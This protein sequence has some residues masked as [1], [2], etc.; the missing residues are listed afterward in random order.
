[1][2]YQKK[3]VEELP[4]TP[5][6]GEEGDHA[7]HRYS[8][9]VEFSLLAAVFLAPIAI[10]TV[11]PWSSGLIAALSLISFLFLVFRRRRRPRSFL[12]FPMGLA[13]L[14]ACALVLLQLVPLP[15]GLLGFISPR[16]REI[17]DYLLAGTL[18]A[19]KWQPVS[20]DP[21][22]T[23]MDL[24]RLMACALVFVV[25]ANYFNDRQRAR[26]VLKTIALS[27]LMVAIV[28]LLSKLFSLPG[29]FGLYPRQGEFFFGT[30]INPN[31]QAAFLT[32]ATL[33]AIGLVLS[34]RERQ[35]KV[36]FAACAFFSG[37]AV[38]LTLSR[39][40][41]VAFF[42]GLV[43][44]L[45]IITTGQSARL[46]RVVLV[47]A[48]AIGLLLI[49]GYLA[50]DTIVRE[51]RTLGDLQALRE[52]TKFNSW[53]GTLQM[54]ADFPLLG[55]GKGAYAV[56]YHRYKTVAAEA[57]FTHAENEVLEVISNL[58]FLGGVALI[59]VFVLSFFM[60]LRRTRRSMS[61]ASLAAAAFAVAG[62][63]LVDFNL[64]TGGVAVPF[65]ALLGIMAASPFSHAGKPAHWETAL[66]LSGRLAMVLAPLLLASAVICWY[67]GWRHDLQLQ[68]EH[69]L[70]AAREKPA[71]PCSEGKLGA[72]SC[73]MLE[74]HRA[75]FLTPLVLGKAYLEQQPRR[76]LERAA[77][78]LARAMYL[79]PSSPQAHLFMG[80]ALY[81]LGRQNQALVEYRLAVSHRPQLLAAVTGEL[82]RLSGDARQVIAATPPSASNYLLVAHNL[83]SLGRKDA[84]ETAASLALEQEGSNVS[85][86]ELLVD[87]ALEQNQ[88]PRAEELV[89]RMLEINPLYDRAHLLLGTVKLRRGDVQAAEKVWSEGFEQIPDSSLLAY[90]LVEF[91]LSQGRLSEAE[92]VASRLQR[93]A[94][95]D[96]RSQARLLALMGRIHESK[97]ML[98]EAR[99]DFQSATQ[100]DPAFPG[101]QLDIARLEEAL[102][103][104]DEAEKIYNRLL[105]E[106]Y[107]AAEINARLQKLQ[108]AKEKALQDAMREVWLKNE[109][110]R[111][112]PGR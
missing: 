79:N 55:V 20:L 77:H 31:H 15:P 60:A 111:K 97:G 49:A 48:I 64:E 109:E 73:S 69:L 26:R 32:L 52:E 75:D 106:N 103:N 53:K 84:A 61:L 93:I 98:F 9:L 39:G 85:A 36:F 74:H 99:R 63:N 50:Y 41:I 27:G 46:K 88:L 105:A 67:Y 4:S 34:G 30:F 43:L 102:G 87:L 25:V 16:A 107:R 37:A 65:C 24:V 62:H 72:I 11:H 86:L 1:M 101:Y 81:F 110:G 104:Y 29:I 71:E 100:L 91:Y 42:A 92:Q 95:S 108:Q 21:P 90:R 40:G 112:N 22:S 80:R 17:G 54:I 70:E 8:F 76:N 51:L 68:T 59:A 56:A 57:T 10:G 96:S 13:L 33:V 58:G 94:P 5:P 28:A 3:L 45:V 23:A 78:W 6:A 19:A 35:G 2:P 82:M 12:L 47:Q 7:P 38:L 44:L 89:R 66:R 83:R 18:L 14:G